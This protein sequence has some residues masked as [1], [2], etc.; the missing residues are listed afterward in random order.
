MNFGHFAGINGLAPFDRGDGRGN[1]RDLP[2]RLVNNTFTFT[3]RDRGVAYWN[4]STSGITLNIPD[5]RVF[6]R[7]P[8]GFSLALFTGSSSGTITVQGPAGVTILEGTG[9]G[10]FV[11]PAGSSRLLAKIPDTL[12]QWRLW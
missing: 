4:T 5:E 6:G 10:S 3:K 12:N 11:I 9:T 8:N 2:P 1:V 7:F